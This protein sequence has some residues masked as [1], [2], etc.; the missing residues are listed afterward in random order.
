M[1]KG[2]KSY[3]FSELADL[4]AQCGQASFRAKQL[5]RWLYVTGVTSYDEMTNLPQSFKKQLE[6]IAPLY[7][8]RI[9]DKQISHDGTRK[10]VIEYYDG[11]KVEAVGMPSK[12]SLSVCFST[13]AG[14]G[15]NCSFC[16]TGTEGLTRNLSAGEM[17]DQLLLV[18]HDFQTRISHVVSMGQG[19]PFQ[20]YDAVLEAL[21]FFN[22]KKGFEIGARHITISTCGIIS[23]ILQLAQEPEQFTLAVS[24]HAARQEIRDNLMPR[25]ASLPLLNLKDALL[26]Y[27]SKTGRRV[28]LE[29]IM[30]KDVND[31]EQD[32]MALKDFC[33]SLLCHI[34]LI[35]INS[36]AHALY[37]PSSMKTLEYWVKE[38]NKTHKEATIRNSRGSDING[39]CGQLK[40]KQTT[41]SL[42]T[43]YN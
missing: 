37:Q 25:C 38:L 40:N 35:P 5:I 32:L 10:Y 15:M 42:N 8:S 24:L 33:N 28:S 39:A 29:Y 30:I 17:I 19:E 1:K 4:C 18:Q 7:P 23:G 3:T 43:T 16:A 41:S 31:T 26:Q 6:E 36:V 34:N 2:I 14:C 9:I 20:N 13:Q 11:A 21:R 27:V 22:D 12:K